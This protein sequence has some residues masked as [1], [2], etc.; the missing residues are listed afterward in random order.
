MENLIEK[1]AV[2]LSTFNIFSPNGVNGSLVESDRI[3]IPDNSFKML[4]DFPLTSPTE[5]EVKST[6]NGFS[7]RE[8]IY[9]LK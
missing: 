5:V 1:T 3:V 8:L 6:S 4:I 2:Q 9:S 7:L